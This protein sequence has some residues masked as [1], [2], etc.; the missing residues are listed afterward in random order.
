LTYDWKAEK[1]SVPINALVS[2]LVHVGPQPVSL[3]VGVRY[4]A[5]SP[6]TGPHGF[7]ARAVVTFLFPK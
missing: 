2:K 3:G 7:G 1:W 5:S 6:N 4:W